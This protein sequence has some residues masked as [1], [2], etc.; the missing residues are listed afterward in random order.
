MIW[1]NKKNGPR[2]FREVDDNRVHSF[3]DF[4][5][6]S[7]IFI[8]L[9]DNLE[10]DAYKKDFGIRVIQSDLLIMRTEKE[11]QLWTLSSGL[12]EEYK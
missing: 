11:N 6:S 10:V 12:P 1:L 4:Y 2:K 7:C 3:I 5:N 8:N 9:V